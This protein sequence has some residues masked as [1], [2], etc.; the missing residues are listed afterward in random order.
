LFSFIRGAWTRVDSGEL[1]FSI[2]SI[3]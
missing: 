3:S 2:P 1:V